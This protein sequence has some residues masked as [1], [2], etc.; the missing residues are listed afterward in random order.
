VCVA[1]PLMPTNVQLVSRTT[2]SLNISWDYPDGDWSTF[3]VSVELT[4]ESWS[5]PDNWCLID[6]LP[7]AGEQYVFNVTTVSR[8]KSSSPYTDQQVTGQNNI[9]IAFI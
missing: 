4:N 1:D 6:N 5:T 3:V 7:I 9:I 2:D 8:D